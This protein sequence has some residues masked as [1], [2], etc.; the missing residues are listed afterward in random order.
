M[1]LVIPEELAT[2]EKYLLILFLSSECWGSN[3]CLTLLGLDIAIRIISDISATNSCRTGN[4]SYMALHLECPDWI[5]TTEET[6]FL[7]YV[8]DQL[9]SGYPVLPKSHYL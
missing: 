9:I 1:A 8:I 7:A 3:S 6:S 2:G 5:G 4:I